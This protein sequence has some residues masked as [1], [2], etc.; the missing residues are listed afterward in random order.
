M[1]F[2]YISIFV[3]DFFHISQYV[4]KYF[5]KSLLR[6]NPEKRYGKK[7]SR[8]NDPLSGLRYTTVIPGLND[9]VMRKLLF[10]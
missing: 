9:A 3:H 7:P 6:P 5:S 8:W 1:F 4:K 2:P 10:G